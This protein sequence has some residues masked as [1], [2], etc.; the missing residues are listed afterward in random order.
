[1]VRFG[2]GRQKGMLKDVIGNVASLQDALRLVEVPVNAQV[3]P[4]LPVLLLRLSQRGKAARLKRAHVPVVIIGDAIELVGNQ[5]K[6]DCIGTEKVA[7]RFEQRAAESSMPG[8]I[9]RKRRREIGA[10]E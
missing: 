6:R 3:N 4:A 1:M 5:C 8:R 10:L 7:K 2:I 9:R